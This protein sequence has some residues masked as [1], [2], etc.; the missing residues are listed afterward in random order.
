MSPAR[1]AIA[2]YIHGRYW[3]HRRWGASDQITAAAH[4]AECYIFVR[5]GYGFP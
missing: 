3:L 2:K 4:G 5:D 1:Q